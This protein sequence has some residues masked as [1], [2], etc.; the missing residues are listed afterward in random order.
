MTG[1]VSNTDYRKS[2]YTW[3]DG[4]RLS[5]LHLIRYSSVKRDAPRG[6]EL[7]AALA[8]LAEKYG[9]I[10]RGGRCWLHSPA[11][12]AQAVT[13]MEH[14]TGPVSRGKDG[15]ELRGVYFAF[16]SKEDQFDRIEGR[17]WC[18]DRFWYDRSGENGMLC[19][20]FKN[21]I[22]DWIDMRRGLSP[23][24]LTRLP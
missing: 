4:F 16:C 1:H 22:S 11:S 18:W 24:H 20:T 15:L 7:I 23:H 3:V 2:G 10:G 9:M 14:W 6:R 5:R 17:E 12:F 8:G 19:R 13:I 21:I